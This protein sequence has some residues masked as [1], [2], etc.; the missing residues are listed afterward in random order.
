[1]IYFELFCVAGLTYLGLQFMEIPRLELVGV[2]MF[3]MAAIIATAMAVG[4]CE[5]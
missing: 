3:G 5:K 1:M 4:V 2:F